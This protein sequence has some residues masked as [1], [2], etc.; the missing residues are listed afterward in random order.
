[1]STGSIRV[2]HVAR[3]FRVYPQQQRTLK[4]LFVA[5]RRVRGTDVWALRDVSFSVEPGEAIGLIGRNGS[6]KTTLL[7]LLA[8]IIRPT[9]GR[10]EV[11]GRVGSLLELGAGFHP[12]FTG[13]ENV[14]LN[15]SIHG[16]SRAAV[17]RHLDEIVAFAGLEQFIDLPVRTYSSGMAMRLGFA[18]AA[19]L[20]ADVLL[21]D[22]VF[23]VG[24]EEFQ[25]RCFG[26]IFEFKQRGGTIVFVSHDAAAV[27]R[28]CERAVLLRE[29]RVEVDGPT[30]EALARYHRLLAAER[31]PEERVAGLR[32]WGTGEA[33]VAEVELLGSAGEPRRQFL[34]G[35]PL[36]LRL[37]LVAERPLAAPRLHY[38]LRSE[39]GLLVAGG[40]QDTAELG[41]PSAG[42]ELV[43]RFDVDRL[44][45]A[46][47]RFHLRVG[48]AGE[49][50]RLVHQLDEAATFLVVPEGEER[51]FAR[52]D[53]RWTREEIAAPAELRVR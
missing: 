47:G 46:D 27:E 45:L 29:G 38:E 8:E 3:R 36:S 41:W 22:E 52:V 24:D 18:V 39:S 5:R 43:L 15:G 49:D 17:R 20:E 25:R 44:P 51:G 4:E 12:D 34:A 9:S 48:L 14:Y 6:G 37:R 1:V 35:E 7:R 30:H 32:E 19:H 13:R 16:L 21:L 53:G 23:A 33:R 11:G 50:G 40:V 42:G 2:E 10:V 26:K 31:D 28:L